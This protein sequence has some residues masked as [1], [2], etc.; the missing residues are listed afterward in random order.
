MPYMVVFTYDYLNRR[1]RKL[2]YAWDPNEGASGDWSTSSGCV[3]FGWAACG[4]RQ[5]RGSAGNRWLSLISPCDEPR[6]HEVHS[7]CED[8]ANCGGIGM[9]RAVREEISVDTAV[10]TRVTKVE[11]GDCV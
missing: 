5:R 10:A 9:V 3:R 11:A 1:V 4:R 2:V 7:Y 8:H 6:G